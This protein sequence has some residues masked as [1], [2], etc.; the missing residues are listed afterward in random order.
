M[1]SPPY[2]KQYIN[3]GIFQSLVVEEH[4]MKELIQP[5]LINFLEN[6][7]SNYVIFEG[8]NKIYLC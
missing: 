8:V 3:T 2:W 6:W 5:F 4:L 7:K 1:F